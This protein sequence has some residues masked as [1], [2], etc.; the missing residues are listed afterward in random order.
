[1]RFLFVIVAV[2]MLSACTTDRYY[3]GEYENQLYDFYKH[4]DK[5]DSLL[6]ALETVIEHGEQSGHIPPGIYAEYGYLML[7][8]GDTDKALKSF[9]R[10]KEIWPESAYFMDVMIRNTENRTKQS[11]VTN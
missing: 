4:P 3:W 1:M 11:T 2:V 9:Q 7:V 5:M 10:E 8:K 6:I